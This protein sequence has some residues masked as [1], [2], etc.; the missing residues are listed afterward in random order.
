[1]LNVIFFVHL[2]WRPRSEISAAAKREIARCRSDLPRYRWQQADDQ[3]T[4]AHIRLDGRLLIGFNLV[5]HYNWLQ[6]P[7]WL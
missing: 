7:D 6:V 3:S 2:L 1:M 5:Y 4:G